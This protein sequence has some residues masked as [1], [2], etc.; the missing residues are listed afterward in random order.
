MRH[1]LLAAAIGAALTSSAFA[2]DLS[3]SN[4][5]S[6]NDVVPLTYVGANRRFSI[7][8]SERG[9]FTGEILSIFAYNGA[10]AFLAESWYGEGGAYGFKGAYNW[11]WG[12]SADQVIEDPSK[13]LVAKGFL[14]YDRNA[15]E[16]DKLTLGF[17]LERND[18]FGSA[19]LMHGLS[20]ER[21]VGA[22]TVRNVVTQTGTDSGRPFRQD[23]ITDSLFETFEQAYD[24]GL[25]VRGGR[26][27]NAHLW[28]LRGGLD[29]ERGDFASDQLVGSVGVDKYFENTGHSV[30]LEMAHAERDGDF[31][32][33]DS[34][35]RVG[36]VYRYEFGDSFRPASWE[37]AQNQPT[38]A[39]I[40]VAKAMAEPKV[41]QNE[42]RMSSDAFFDFDKSEIRPETKAELDTLIAQIKAA[43]LGGPITI[44]GHTCDIGTDNYNISL[45]QRR[46]QAVK[47]FF[48]SAGILDELI[49][50]GKGEAEPKFPNSRDERRKNRRVDINFV[51]IE[52]TTESVPVEE[53]SAGTTNATWTRAE[54][55]VPPG[56]VERALKNM[57]EHKRQVDTYTFVK[58][59]DTQ[60]QGPRT[61]INRAPVAANDTVTV[62]R[63]ASATLINVLANDTDADPGDR[64]VVS[65]VTQPANGSV[66]NVGNGVVYTP[67]RDFA[68]S[69]SFTYTIS[70]GNG[71]SATAT[72][73]ITVADAP[74]I[75]VDDTA[76]TARNTPVEIN[77]LANDSDPDGPT[78]NLVEVSTP[79][80][81]RAEI[82]GNRVR[83]T[84]NSNFAGIERFTY[85]IRDSAGNTARAN[86]TVTVANAA[87]IAVD[88]TERTLGTAPVTINVLANDRDPE[89]DS[90]TV[91][92]VSTP[93]NGRAF[94]DGNRVVYTANAGFAGVDTFTYVVRDAFG[95]TATGTVRVTVDA[96][97]APTANADSVA[98][99]KGGTAEIRVL[100]NDV[101]PEG[102]T[103][104]ITRIVTQP[105]KGTATIVGNVVV[106][107][108]TPGPVGSDSFEYEIA[109]PAGNTA[110]GR[111]SVAIRTFQN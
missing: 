84:P 72:V 51:T 109:D 28:R 18:Y 47:E 8:I 61:F 97:R 65:S 81:G 53:T 96:N 56:W 73:N 70:D 82:I 45:S 26:F 36:F 108:H 11:L 60:S 106:Y 102:E 40:P 10:R 7:G 41:M 107:R 16:D 29:Y 21:L 35:T 74:P 17:G 1:S 49:S 93:A 13:A 88:D 59:T 22:R 75:A 110:V 50:D 64:L 99:L 42:I 66:Q 78:P 4:A 67:R 62:Q 92:S 32:I 55:T 23:L 85:T 3:T 101:D 95:A 25:G 69:E 24:R 44:V 9:Y 43:K 52:T 105:G 94:I 80:N 5:D 33:D 98:L 57:A 15:F 48:I 12:M 83:Y 71:G 46:A 54:V 89:G 6:D 79:A 38:V 37:V 30:S 2:Q 34:D 58:R 87:P 111:V 77:V 76:T 39:P 63:N 100:D 86:V 104:R 20:D 90:L 31:A 68:G 91:V 103:L 27:F 14:A 19:Y